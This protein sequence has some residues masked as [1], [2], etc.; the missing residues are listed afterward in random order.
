MRWAV[1][2]LV[3]VGCGKAPDPVVDAGPPVAPSEATLLMQRPYTPLVPDAGVPDAGWPLLIV[4]HGYGGT[5]ESTMQTLHLQDAA[6]R[7]AMVAPQGKFDSR[8]NR[9]W[10]PGPEHSPYW[11]VE[12][13]TAIIHDMQAKHPIDPARV[14]VIG[15]SQGAHMAH[16]MG[17]DASNDLAA[18]VSVAGQVTT[19]PSACAP[20]RQ[21]SVLQ[22]HGD[23][24][25]AVGYYGDVQHNPPDP[26]VP[27]AHET[28]AVWARNDGCSGGL[29]D[30]GVT[31]DLSRTVDGGETTVAAYK[32][33][34]PGI[35]VELWTMQGVGHTPYATS[36]FVPSIETFLS[37]HPR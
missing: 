36:Q 27:S 12:Y 4:L 3:V 21:V 34:P 5:A 11:D 29:V 14:F 6:D 13:L 1:I 26:S 2:G 17:C 18:V 25:E 16:R 9:A 7:F 32:G 37:A 30:T 31:L 28:V 8:H 19:V 20:A 15:H 23:E 22:I 10:H 24:D 33:C 35:A